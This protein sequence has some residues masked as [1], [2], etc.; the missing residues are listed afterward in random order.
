MT[1]EAVLSFGRMAME[2]LIAVASPALL[3]ALALAAG[4]RLA[5]AIVPLREV[6]P[7]RVRQFRIALYILCGLGAAS[8]LGLPGAALVTDAARRRA[9]RKA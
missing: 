9:K 1:P 2:I 3:T 4:A 5:D 6:F 7:A 8:Y